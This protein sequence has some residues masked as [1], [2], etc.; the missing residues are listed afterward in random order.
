MRSRF[1]F[2]LVFFLVFFLF[3]FVGSPKKGCVEAKAFFQWCNYLA[4][5]VT[6]SGK[7]PLY[8]K[9]DE[10]PVKVRWQKLRGRGRPERTPVGILL[11]LL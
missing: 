9:V 1:G 3:R 11:W 8:I 4:D 7:A 10:T 5:K 2:F 6:G